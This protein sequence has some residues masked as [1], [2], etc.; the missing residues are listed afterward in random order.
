MRG[1]AVNP[2]EL[3]ARDRQVFVC[4][5]VKEMTI[6]D[7]AKHLGVSG[8]TIKNTQNKP[9]Y[10]QLLI[11][12][13]GDVEL[14]IDAVA[15]GLKEATQ[16]DRMIGHP[17]LNKREADHVTR[18]NAWKAVLDVYGAVAPKEQLHK[19]ELAMSSDVEMNVLIEEFCEV[20]DVSDPEQPG[21]Q[22]EGDPD[23]PASIPVTVPALENQRVGEDQM[24]KES[25]IQGDGSG[26]IV[27]SK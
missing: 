15:Q 11:D 13:M 7:T 1:K 8:Q 4:R 21:L 23:S 16:A 3:T 26:N 5:K 27:Q 24:A 18:L 12:K 19:H 25:Q 2:Y 9:A 17:G 20:Y 10:N 6:K 22:G 14:G